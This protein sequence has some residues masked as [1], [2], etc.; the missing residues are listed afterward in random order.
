MLLPPL[1]SI[2]LEL[3]IT[4]IITTTTSFEKTL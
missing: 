1:I 2:F 4:C 3:I